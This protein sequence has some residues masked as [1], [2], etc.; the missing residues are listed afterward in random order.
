MPSPADN[1]P[2]HDQ[3]REIYGRTVYSHKTHIIQA[4]M[5]LC[6]HGWIK[7][8]QI[9]L[10]ATTTAGVITAF[11]GKEYWGLGISALTSAVLTALI[12]YTKDF[13]LG[14]IASE[15]K[16]TSDQLWHIREK[17]LD[18]I[19]DLQT[20]P[21]NAD[22]IRQRRDALRE[23]L[24]KVYSAARITSPKAYGKA[25]KA[26]KLNEDMTFTPDEIDMFLPIGLR[27]NK[28]LKGPTVS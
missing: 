26:L 13:D 2:L 1:E 10:G 8:A 28:A 18:L 17:Y 11:L 23:D 9:A 14:T 12:A 6:K 22:E 20:A 4:G 3:L 7:I 5:D 16:T 24:N 15:H 19:T 25:Q 27:K 21:I